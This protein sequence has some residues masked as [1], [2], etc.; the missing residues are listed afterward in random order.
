VTFN[1]AAV[2]AL[3]SAAVSEAQ[4][5]GIFARVNQHEPKNAPGAQLSCSFW[6]GGIKPVP[7]ASGLNA[8]SGVVTLNA[9]I[10]ASFLAKPEDATDP[11]I[12]SAACALLNA[13]SGGFTLGETVRDIDLLGQYGEALSATAAYMEQDGK[14]FR[15]M[16]VTIPVVIS[17]LF[18]QEA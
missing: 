13:Y 4:A 15:V 11:L 9:R 5:L 16:E 1:A 14:L 2:S 6:V 10:Y 18:T 17:D 7:A 3:F 12:L 8:T